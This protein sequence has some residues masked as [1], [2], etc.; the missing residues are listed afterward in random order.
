MLSEDAYAYFRKLRGFVLEYHANNI[1][2]VCQN[3]VTVTLVFQ[4]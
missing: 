1:V 3:Q 2:L 4:G